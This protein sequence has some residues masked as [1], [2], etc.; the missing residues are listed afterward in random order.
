ML[1]YSVPSCS[2][3]IGLMVEEEM[4]KWSSIAGEGTRAVSGSEVPRRR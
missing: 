3:I 4:D 1:G 2:K